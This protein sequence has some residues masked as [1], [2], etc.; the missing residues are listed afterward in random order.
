[1]PKTHSQHAYIP[2]FLTLF[3]T[4]NC[5]QKPYLEPISQNYVDLSNP[6][7]NIIIGTVLNCNGYVGIQKQ[8]MHIEA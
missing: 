3:G 8:N 5:N 6:A 7:N 4:Y 1:M 2:Y